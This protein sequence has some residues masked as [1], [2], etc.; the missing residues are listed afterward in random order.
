MS[1]TWFAQP[2]E[3]VATYWR[4]LRRDGVTL[5][6]TSHDRDVW[7]E[8]V[9]HRAS[10]GMVPSAIRRNAGLEEDSADVSGA[11]SHDAINAADLAAGRYDGAR[12][13]IGLV[14]WSTGVSET[15]W[16][17]SLGTVSEED[18]GF[19]AELVSRKAELLRSAV[20]RTSPACRAAFCGPGCTL[21]P[22]FFTHEAIVG[23]S[24]PTTS[25]VSL[26]CDAPPADLVGGTLQW[27][28]GPGAGTTVPI[29]A[30]L[31][32][33]ALVLA[34][35]PDTPVPAGARALVREGCDHRLDTC[36]DRFANAANFRGEP[37][38]PGND[39]LAR[40]PSPLA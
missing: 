34:P 17:G 23:A 3:T 29:R 36:A 8:G 4:V 37:F 6:F 40:Y 27:L 25:S 22:A 24:D 20:P 1:R 13:R 10:P 21:S 7:F 14:D 18:H 28:D 33:G 2:L 32:D 5:G 38:L 19:S 12:V 11:L 39:L 26:M 31:E 16:V 9:L 30:A 35:Y 15:V